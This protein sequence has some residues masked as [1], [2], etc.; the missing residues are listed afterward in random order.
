MHY[1]ELR[2]CCRLHFVKI[3][4]QQ[5]LITALEKKLSDVTAQKEDFEA[6]LR[7]KEAAFDDLTE[8]F[9]AK[10]EELS[11]EKD[12]HELK[13][14]ECWRLEEEI[15]DLKRQIADLL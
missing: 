5:E 7:A 11:H 6:R 3:A 9:E 4:A 13:R 12:A 8:R 1:E 14:E 2:E 15:K 10:S